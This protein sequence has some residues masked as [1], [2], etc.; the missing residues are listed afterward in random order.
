[1]RYMR[2]TLKYASTGL[3]VT[4]FDTNLRS[5]KGIEQLYGKGVKGKVIMKIDLIQ[6]LTDCFEEETL[7]KTRAVILRVAQGTCTAE[8]LEKIINVYLAEDAQFRKSINTLFNECPPKMAFGHYL[9]YGLANRMLAYEDKIKQSIVGRSEF[10]I[11]ESD[12]YIYLS[13]PDVEGYEFNLYPYEVISHA[14]NWSIS[15]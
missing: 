3:D 14:K 11:C 15:N 7:K 10:Y 8:M 5:Y 1:M 2:E 4:Y 12:G 13:F 6:C 9:A